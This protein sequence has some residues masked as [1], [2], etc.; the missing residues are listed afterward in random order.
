MALSILGR[1]SFSRS[2]W[3]VVVP[4]IPVFT[5]GAVT[6]D[7]GHFGKRTP[8]SG[9]GPTIPADVRRSPTNAPA[10]KSR[11]LAGEAPH[12]KALQRLSEMTPALPALGGGML[13]SYRDRQARIRSQKDQTSQQEA[14]QE[15]TRFLRAPEL[16]TYGSMA[17]YQRKVLDLIGANG[18]IQQQ[19]MKMQGKDANVLHLEQELKVLEAMTPVELASNHKSVF[20]R[21]AIQL[22]AEKAGSTVKFVDQVLL[23]H[24]ILRAD[25]RWYRILEQF[26][27]PL[28]KTFEERGLMAEY[29][30]PYGEAELEERDKMMDKEQNKM[31]KRHPPRVN[32]IWYRHPTC[33][34]NRW[35]SRPPRWYPL[36]FPMWKDRRRRLGG[37][38]YGSGG[39]GDRG[40]PWGG[41]AKFSG[42][43]AG[44][45]S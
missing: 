14:F 21:E 44:A 42:R 37:V 22:I 24:D 10:I 18:F 16:W 38:G 7:S 13:Q 11:L 6:G 8:G 28:P 4:I 20:T 34:G 33:G 39:G 15:A 41:L 36:R 43:S 3:Q 1:G 17:A 35:S 30:R 25:R 19:M 31:S 26:G 5:R 29:D 23:E 27:R 9:G 32:K 12:H 45:K 40:Q 2:P